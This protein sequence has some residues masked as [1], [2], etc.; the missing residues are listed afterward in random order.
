MDF[1]RLFYPSGKE[2]SVAKPTKHSGN[3]DVVNKCTHTSKLKQ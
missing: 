3:K 1:E 2:C